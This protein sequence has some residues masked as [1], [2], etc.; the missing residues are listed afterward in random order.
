MKRDL[1]PQPPSLLGK[2]EKEGNSPLKSHKKLFLFSLWCIKNF[3]YSPSPLRR[4]P[5]R[6]LF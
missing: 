3:S 4:G 5:G 1:T 6:G 2:G